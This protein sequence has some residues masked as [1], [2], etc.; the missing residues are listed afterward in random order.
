MVVLALACSQ[1]QNTLAAQEAAG[2]KPK[3]LG[4]SPA[5]APEPALRYRLI[6]SSADLNPGDAAPIYLRLRHEVNDPS[7]N[8][9][10]EKW[11]AWHDLPLGKLPVKEA[12]QFVDKWVART[13]QLEFGSRR[14]FCDWSYTLPEQKLDAIGILLPDCQSMRQWAKLLALKAKVEIADHNYENAIETLET[15]IAFGRH[16]ADGPFLISALVGIAICQN[17]LDRVEDLVA[18]PDAPNLYWA[19]TSLPRPLVSFR[20]SLESEHR[21]VENM[22]PELTQADQSR[23]RAAW[24]VLVESLYG[25]MRELAAKLAGDPEAPPTIK[26]Q[27]AVDLE[28]FRR[29][30]LAAGQPYLK[31]VRHV[32][33][34]RLK[35]MSEDELIARSLAYRFRDLR[36]GLFKATY[37][38]WRQAKRQIDLNEQRYKAGSHGSMATIAYLMPSQGIAPSLDAGMR[39]DRRVALL[40]VIEAMRLHAASNDHSLPLSLE[41]IEDVPVPFDPATEEP[42]RYRREGAA[43]LLTAP[44]PIG[45]QSGPSFRLTIRS[46]GESSK[47]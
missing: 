22:V 25:R 4:L 28:S 45:K 43:G 31:D 10:E 32:E 39:L 42:F 18:Q 36:D 16:V 35:T 47:P 40:R 21:L 11:V 20:T 3:E 14:A 17:M 46:P 19:L 9:I 13:K 27:L 30:A 41:E 1:G 26:A 12:R 38:P 2:D 15:G 33:A 23:T 8:E 24:K 7:W 29:E 37:L 44:A 34:N 6:P 5:R